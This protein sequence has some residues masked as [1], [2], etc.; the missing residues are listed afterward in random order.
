MYRLKPA[1]RD[2]KMYSAGQRHPEQSLISAYRG[3]PGVVVNGTLKMLGQWMYNDKP[4]STLARMSLVDTMAGTS[5]YLGVLA[6]RQMIDI[7]HADFHGVLR[8]FMRWRKM[9]GAR[10]HQL[11]PAVELGDGRV[12]RVSDGCLWDNRAII[13]ALHGLSE[14]GLMNARPLIFVIAANQRRMQWWKEWWGAEKKNDVMMP[15]ATLFDGKCQTSFTKR[16]REGQM[17]IFEGC[18]ANN[19]GSLHPFVNRGIVDLVVFDFAANGLNSLP[20]NKEMRWRNWLHKIRRR[21]RWIFE[22]LSVDKSR[23]IAVAISGGGA[24]TALM[25]FEFL[26]ILKE[27]H[28]TPVVLAGNSGGA[29]AITLFAIHDKNSDVLA[30]MQSRLDELMHIDNPQSVL[31]MIIRNTFHNPETAETLVYLL[32][33]LQ[34]ICFDW[35]KLVS[36]L[37]FGSKPHP[38]WSVLQNQSFMT[39]F[40]VSFLANSHA[41]RLDVI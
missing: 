36:H 11:A 17:L 27:Q 5:A 21:I 28:I 16:M 18:L 31:L 2:T 19:N 10:I 41:R 25:G 39:V 33:L 13:S 1:S 23:P 34:Q 24:R 3:V 15:E 7:I 22:R 20:F 9:R 6:D 38:N 30:L 26:Q 37:L 14:R 8:F 32:P 4:M 40:P 29:W 35:R 12:V